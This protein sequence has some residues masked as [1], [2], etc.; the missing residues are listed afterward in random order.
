MLQW[1]DMQ[2]VVLF[3]ETGSIS[4]AHQGFA[5]RDPCS[6]HH[7]SGGIGSSTIKPLYRQPFGRKMSHWTFSRAFSGH[8]HLR[9]HCP[10][11]SIASTYIH[12]SGGRF[13]SGLQLGYCDGESSIS[14][15]G[16]DAMSRD[17]FPR[18]FLAG[19]IPHHG[20][21]N[22]WNFLMVGGRSRRGPS[23]LRCKVSNPPS[24]RVS[25][26]VSGREH[27]ANGCESP[28]ASKSGRGFNL[29]SVPC[30]DT[31]ASMDADDITALHARHSKHSA[32]AGFDHLEQEASPRSRG[33]GI[34]IFVRLLAW[35]GVL[36]LFSFR[37]RIHTETL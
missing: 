20:H 12:H 37:C 30:P 32:P 6:P 22:T 2:S 13:I 26:I 21:R 10:L 9:Y 16:I 11:H 24:S 18:P 31:T 35:Y 8:T 5:L 1:Q 15:L 3:W 14:Q 29:G 7:L 25:N 23:W 19:R 4:W 17:V 34:D 33:S 28:R 36:C 27:R